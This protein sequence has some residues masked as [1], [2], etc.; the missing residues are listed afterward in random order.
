MGP[1]IKDDGSKEPWGASILYVI[2]VAIMAGVVLWEQFKVLLRP[3]EFYPVLSVIFAVCLWLF[4]IVPMVGMGCLLCNGE[5][6]ARTRVAMWVAKPMAVF[7]VLSA[8]HYGVAMMIAMVSYFQSDSFSAVTRALWIWSMVA[9]CVHVVN[10]L[11]SSMVS[12]ACVVPVPRKS[13]LADNV[14]QRTAGTSAA[15]SL[16]DASSRGEYDSV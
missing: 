4:E 7:S 8:I 12:V 3:H 13:T 16:Q 14:V 11:L 10:L 1:E 9:T 15:T 2:L 5:L 6:K